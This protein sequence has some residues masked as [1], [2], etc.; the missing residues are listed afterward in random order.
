MRNLNKNGTYL[1]LVGV[2][3][4][5]F[6]SGCAIQPGGYA[7]GYYPSQQESYPMLDNTV[8]YY[9]GVYSGGDW[10][11]NDNYRGGDNGG[12]NRFGREDH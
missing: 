5:V 10:N 11:N 7:T 12:D 3:T 2:L 4:V 8:P 9:G 1:A 6:L